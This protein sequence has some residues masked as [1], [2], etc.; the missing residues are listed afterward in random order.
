MSKP[1]L[2]IVF[3][4]PETTSRVFDVIR[5][6]KPKRLYI[7]ADGPRVGKDKDYNKCREVRRIVNNV[8]WECEVRNLFRENNLGC[9]YAVSGAIDWFF[10]NEEEGIILE[11]DCLPDQSF[12]M[13]CETLLDRYRDDENVMCISGDNFQF[14]NDSC[15]ESYYY[16][17]YTHIWGWASWR[18]AW[19]RY[20]VAMNQWPDYKSSGKMKSKFD[21]RLAVWYWT[22]I[23]DSVYRG[24]ID[25]W[26]Y[27]WL[28][29][30]LRHDGLNVIPRVNLISNIGFGDDST[31]TKEVNRFFNIKT[32]AIKQPLIGPLQKIYNAPAD[33]YTE[34]KMFSGTWAEII[35]RKLS[36]ALRK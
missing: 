34:S 14:N 33:N 5:A 9:K 11:D 35:L 16:S 24:D 10:E 19:K 30:S 32:E 29:A 27:Q 18:R 20:D 4:R 17:R 8:D 12:F 25:T 36:N 21:S 2:F 26:D 22:R 3:N 6:A 1:I 31:H 13:F 23:F 28:F 7:A 15:K